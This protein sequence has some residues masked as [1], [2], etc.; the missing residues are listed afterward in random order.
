MDFSSLPITHQDTISEDYI[1]FL[2]HMNVMWY[3][4]LFDEAVYEFWGMFGCGRDYH[5]SSSMGSFALEQHI[6]YLAEVRLG[7][8]VTIRSR[9]LG[10]SAK[11]FHFMHFMVR[12]KDDVLAAT[13][14]F[15]GVHIDLST[16]RSKPFP[17]DALRKLDAL[18]EAHRK[19]DW[20]APVCGVMGVR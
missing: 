10:R 4:H 20:E 9:A 18:L 7:D 5:N 19:L 11:T 17:K 1:D 16:R 15:V 8:S 3:T 6:R 12:D 13:G 14:E 2:G